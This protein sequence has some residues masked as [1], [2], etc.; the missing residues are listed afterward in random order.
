MKP[1]LDKNFCLNF[2]RLDSK[3]SDDSSFIFSFVGLILY[4][5]LYLDLISVFVI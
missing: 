2:C 3:V 4:L 1:D 5:G